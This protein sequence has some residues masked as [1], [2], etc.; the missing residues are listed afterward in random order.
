MLEVSTSL[1]IKSSVQKEVAVQTFWEY[2]GAFAFWNVTAITN[3]STALNQNSIIDVYFVQ[4]SLSTNNTTVVIDMQTNT[5]ENPM[6]VP[7]L[8]T[9]WEE[10]LQWK[11]TNWSQKVR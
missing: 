4:C 3:L 7:Q 9:Q 11:S 5:P 2:P 8:S 6:P 10:T 1:E